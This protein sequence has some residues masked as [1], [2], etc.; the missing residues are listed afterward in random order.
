MPLSHNFW[1]QDEGCT[2]HGETDHARRK[3]SRIERKFL[4]RF[5]FSRTLSGLD[6]GHARRVFGDVQRQTLSKV[7]MHA[8]MTSSLQWRLVTRP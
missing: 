5:C 1:E 2:T 7:C 3:F 8:L 4:L 6:A